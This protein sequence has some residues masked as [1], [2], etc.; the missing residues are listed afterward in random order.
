MPEQANHEMAM[1]IGAVNEALDQLRDTKAKPRK[2]IGF[3]TISN[4]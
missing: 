4:D 1:Q 3:K 2:L